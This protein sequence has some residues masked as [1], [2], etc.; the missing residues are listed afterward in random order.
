MQS[1]T[2]AELRALTGAGTLRR[3]IARLVD[4]GVP[5]RFGGGSVEVLRDVAR[6][7]P[8]WQH[9]EASKAPRLDLVR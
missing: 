5:F 7:L 9:I 1:L 8:Q 2:A 4:M 3:Q 6:C